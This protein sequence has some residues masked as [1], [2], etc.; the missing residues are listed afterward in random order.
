MGDAARAQIGGAL[1]QSLDDVVALIC[2]SEAFIF[3]IVFYH[4]VLHQ[5]LVALHQ[6]LPYLQF[7]HGVLGPLVKLRVVQRASCASLRGERTK[8][9]MTYDTQS[10]VQ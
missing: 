4:V 8:K 7:V 5:E 6:E 2:G 9:S 3:L 1:L 10:H